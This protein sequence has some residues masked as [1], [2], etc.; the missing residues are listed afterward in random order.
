MGRRPL[1]LRHCD[2]DG[3]SPLQVPIKSWFTSL[4]R[5]PLWTLG[6]PLLEE[7]CASWTLQAVRRWQSQDPEDS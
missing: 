6:S 4:S 5:Y 3:D 1:T 2:F 7:S